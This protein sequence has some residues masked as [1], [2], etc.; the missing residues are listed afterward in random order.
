MTFLL[1]TK[2]ALSGD[3]FVYHTG[4][5]ARDRNG[6]SRRAA[7]VRQ[8]AELANDLRSRN[9][10]TLVQRKSERGTEYVVLWR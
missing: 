3:T 6:N 10:A 9:L 2:R 4:H 1:W 5:L 8:N 7:T